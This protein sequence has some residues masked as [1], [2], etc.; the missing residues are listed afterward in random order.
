MAELPAMNFLIYGLCAMTALACTLLMIRAY[1]IS[2]YRLL[3]WSSWCFAGLT[4]HNVILMFDKIVFD[5]DLLT[6]RLVI[7]LMAL[8][9]LVYGLIFENR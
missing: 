3:L 5:N 6:M 8:L 4:L 1:F 7:A 9:P 2:R